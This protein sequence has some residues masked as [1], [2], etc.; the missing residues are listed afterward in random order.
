VA[1]L[2]PRP[3]QRARLA[4]QLCTALTAAI[5]ASVADLRG[6]LG[7]GT[8]DLYSDIDI[9]WLVPD[10]LL[11]AAV[12]SAARTVGSVWPVSSLRFDPGLARSGRRRLIF[13][14]L[15]GLPLFWRID[16]DIR[17]VSV[18]A[19]SEYDDANPAARSEAGWSRPASAIENAAAA[20]K[21]AARGQAAIAD[22]LLSRGYQRI[23]ADPAQADLP[24]RITRLADS[25]AILEPG[26]AAMATEVREVVT[27]LVRAGLL[28][29][30][31]PIARCLPLPPVLLCGLVRRSGRIVQD[32]RCR[33]CAGPTFH[34]CPDGTRFVQRLATALATVTV[35]R[36]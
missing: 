5:P 17:C 21:A 14:R 33:P 31:P 10:G 23:G 7:S 32:R 1:D 20:I 26:L 36:R 13:F 2:D 11:P 8:E 30:E 19:D 27:T 9:G 3:Q 16:L 34:S 22:D 6:S 12:E 18:A 28:P 35:P 4:V 15:A 29:P 24:G 25:C